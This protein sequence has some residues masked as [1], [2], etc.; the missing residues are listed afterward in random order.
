MQERD[1][2]RD[3]ERATDANPFLRLLLRRRGLVLVAALLLMAL[4]GVVG[5]DA[6]DKLA[7]GAYLDP[8]A[9]S[10]TYVGAV[11]AGVSGRAAELGPGRRVD[12]R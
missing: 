4:A 7:S 12:H 1:P 8:S 6:G 11:D 5:R 3:L 9:E 10:Q 2:K